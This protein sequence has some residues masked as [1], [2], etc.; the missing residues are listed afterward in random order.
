MKLIKASSKRNED[1]DRIVGEVINIAFGIKFYNGLKL[2]VESKEKY[3]TF[4]GDNGVTYRIMP[5]IASVFLNGGIQPAD[6]KRTF[7]EVYQRM[8]APILEK[9][10]DL[11][12]SSGHV[13]S[14]HFLL[15][16]K[17]V[18][19]PE[20]PAITLV[21]EL[22]PYTQHQN[23]KFYC[24]IH[25]NPDLIA[26]AD[27]PNNEI[28]KPVCDPE[29]V[30]FTSTVTIIY[31]ANNS[32][33]LP[34]GYT[35]I[36]FPPASAYTK[37][38]NGG[39]LPDVIRYDMFHGLHEQ[40]AWF[41]RVTKLKQ[42]AGKEDQKFPLHNEFPFG[43]FTLDWLSWEDVRPRVINSNMPNMDVLKTD[44]LTIK[45]D[46]EI[47]KE[48]QKDWRC[49]VTGVQLF[50]DIYVLDVY[51]Q[52][53]EKTVDR[54]ELANYPFGTIIETEA[55]SSASKK[56][57]T[58]Q[59]IV[60]FNEPVH[61]LVSPYF[62]HCAGYENPL[63][64]FQDQT[65]MKFHVYRSFCPTTLHSIIEKENISVQ[66]KKVLHELNEAAYTCTNRRGVTTKS[67]L[68]V[69]T[70]KVIDFLTEQSNLVLAIMQPGAHR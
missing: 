68:V 28:G 50:E 36:D 44:F 46:C 65:K 29:L 27:L 53:I 51:E 67:F 48:K 61:L 13:G 70:V 35:D 24:C 31:D 54:S 64:W 21:D 33:C 32:Y 56:T 6:L 26:V 47:N 20:Y 10:P 22:F 17:E 12:F 49:V 4:V 66:F 45:Q 2:N 38:K 52:L 15:I 8:L 37:V 58:I 60:R 3:N 63:K 41:S 40:V 1:I 7:T 9:K 39:L 30:P 19:K 25:S 5:T 55:G 62:V 23:G 43:Q 14:T 59:Y 34:D 16:E 11:K 69:D 18:C 57:V 42:I